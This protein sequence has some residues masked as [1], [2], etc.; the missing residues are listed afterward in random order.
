MALFYYGFK[1]EGRSRVDYFRDDSRE[2]LIK[3]ILSMDN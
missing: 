1:R 3:G 2:F